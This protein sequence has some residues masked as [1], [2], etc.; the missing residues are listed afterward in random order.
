[1]ANSQQSERVVRVRLADLERVILT[2]IDEV[3]DDVDDATRGQIAASEFLARVR[4]QS[5]D[6]D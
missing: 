1:M 6:P 2:L 3:G 5:A 4:A